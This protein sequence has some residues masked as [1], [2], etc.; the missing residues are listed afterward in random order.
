MEWRNQTVTPQPV[1]AMDEEN[2]LRQMVEESSE[3]GRRKPL[4]CSA[5]A[6][7]GMLAPIPMWI[8]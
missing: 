4:F 2:L 6:H 3:K 7:A 8:G 5:P 1:E